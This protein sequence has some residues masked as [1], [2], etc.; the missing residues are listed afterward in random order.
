MSY[1]SFFTASE[2]YQNK[3]VESKVAS[4]PF[5]CDKCGRRFTRKSGLNKH[6]RAVH[7]NI[8]NFLC[9]MCPKKFTQKGDLN[10]HRL[11]I[12][13]KQRNFQCDECDKDFTTK[14]TLKQHKLIV[15]LKERH[16]CV[17][18]DRDFC[19]KGALT[20]HYH[21]F[22]LKLGPKYN[23]IKK[24]KCHLCN[25]R[26]E[27]LGD[28]RRHVVAHVD[29]RLRSKPYKCDKCEKAYFTLGHLNEHKL[30]HLPSA[31]H[32]CGTCGKE[33]NRK[34]HLNKHIAS[35][36]SDIGCDVKQSFKEYTCSFGC[37]KTFD[38]NYHC[39]DHE[40]IHRGLKPYACKQCGKTFNYQRNLTRHQ[41][42]H[43]LRH[44]NKDVDADTLECSDDV[45]EGDEC[46][47]MC[48]HVKVEPRDSEE[49][50][51]TE[52]LE[53]SDNMEDSV[54]MV[55]ENVKIE[56]RDSE[57]DLNLLKVSFE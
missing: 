17:E 55:N 39:K 28:I 10:K 46:T 36:H 54:E 23:S 53:Y 5:K 27:R 51:N 4:T 49:D 56:P 2:R 32:A 44:L 12:H 48:E 22:H 52:H 33:F 19:T 41:K 50:L 21:T 57:E 42:L 47:E 38:S 1:F 14:G 9:D 43:E 35:V 6:I 30:Q 37:G 34:S 11:T 16:E 26:C 3:I 8:R 29:P 20:N 40:L 15:H 24:Y 7:L 45:E 25:R 31:P 13:L 18:C